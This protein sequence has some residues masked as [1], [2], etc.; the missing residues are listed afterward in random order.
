MPVITKKDYAIDIMDKFKAQKICMAVFCTASHWNTEAILL[1]ASRFAEKN[2]I[3]KIPLAVAMT[4]NYPYMPQACR[5]TYGK[6]PKEGFLSVLQH[7]QLLCGREDSS[8]SNVVVLPHLDH[9]DPEKDKWALT[10]GRE[11]LASVMFDAQKYDF[12]KNMS[13]T[14]DYV[15]AYGKDVMVEGVMEGLSVEGST[16]KR[17]DNHYIEKAVQYCARTGVD[18]LVADLGTEQQSSVV[19]RCNYRKDRAKA[20]T[21]ALGKQMLVLHGTS[22]LSRQQMSAL[23]ED[24]VVRVNMW[25]RI[26][27]EAGQ[28]AAERMVERID[29]IRNSDFEASESRQYIEDNIYKASEIMEDILGIL[30][31]GKLSE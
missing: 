2:N 12:E 1:A 16:R 14:A 29:R 13:M 11:Y 4:F 7:L 25:T 23:A 21:D 28:Y 18:F 3:S 15:R 8:Y 26:A 19:G 30:G 10:E 22:C 9:A 17:E 24:G 20:L 27:R 6:N 5:V 31:Y